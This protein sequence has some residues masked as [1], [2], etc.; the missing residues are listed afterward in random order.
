MAVH[1]ADIGHL[2]LHVQKIAWGVAN[3]VEIDQRP[4]A[5][6]L[7]RSAHMRVRAPSSR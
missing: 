2:P 6:M 7:F 3:G 1:A 4:D 5:F